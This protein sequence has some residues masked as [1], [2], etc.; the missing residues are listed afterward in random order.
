LL[1]SLDAARL[2]EVLLE[3]QTQV[4]G[5]PPAEELIVVDGKEP[6]HGPG[7]SILTAVSVPSQT[8]LGSTLVDTKTNEIP[9]ARELFKKLELEGRTVALDAWGIENGTHQRLDVSLNDDRCRVRNPKALLILGMFRRLVISLFME[10][11]A[12]HPKTQ[13]Q[14]LA[15]FQA[16][17]GED[18]LRRTMAFITSQ[19]P[20]L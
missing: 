11:R 14:S 8:D 19:C 3:I 18:N 6:R 15:D 9:V 1:A 7:H 5:Q 20:K 17:M 13:Q 12:K 2:D 10:W 16:A 4:R